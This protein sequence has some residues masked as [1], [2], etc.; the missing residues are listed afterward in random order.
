MQLEKV[1]KAAELQMEINRDI[2]ILGQT[3]LEKANQLDD[4]IGS[5]NTIEEDLFM[6]IIK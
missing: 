3:T 6:E 5:F 4:L 1:K 2:D